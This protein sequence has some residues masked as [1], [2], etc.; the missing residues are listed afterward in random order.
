VTND[1]GERQ[2]KWRKDAQ[3]DRRENRDPDLLPDEA[4]DRVHGR[5]L[6]PATA[7]TVKG[8]E[9]RPT[10]YVGTALLVAGDRYDAVYGALERAAGELGWEVAEDPDYPPPRVR[11]DR[12][13]KPVRDPDNDDGLVPA[14]EDGWGPALRRIVISVASRTAQNAPDAWALLQQARAV[15]DGLD[16]LTGV[17][18]DHVI[19]VH[20]P[21]RKRPHW[22]PN[23]A[24]HWNPNPDSPLGSYGFQG[25]GGR[26]P[27]AY[28]GPRPARHDSVDGGRPV[29]AILDS[30]C[31]RHPW[32]DFVRC[33]VGIDGKAIG[34]VGDADDPEVNGDLVGPLDGGLDPISGHGTFIAGLVHQRC[35]DADIVSWRVVDSD[36]PVVESFALDTLRQVVELVERHADGRPGGMRI[37]VL[38]LSMGYYHETPD[39][40]LED[41]TLKRLLRR[42]GRCGVAVVC[43]AGNDATARRLYPAAYAPKAGQEVPADA[44]YV[45]VTS[46]G[47]DNPNGTVALFSNTGD[48]VRCYA[49]GAAVLSTM[50]P[51]QGGLM[52]MATTR[53]AGLDRESMDPDDYQAFD[54]GSGEMSGGFAL[55]SGTSFAAPVIAGEIAAE[56]LGSIPATGDTREA[57]VERTRAAVETVVSKATSWKRAHGGGTA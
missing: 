31:G 47:A 22:N 50:P 35:P 26:Q 34:Y 43:S 57:A 55:W 39:D 2:D 20:K 21:R 42:L 5:V 44:D 45:P 16:Q 56:L 40:I 54:N 41:P 12:E 3:D 15:A 24:P 37:D 9:P 38:N 14:A 11:V 6:D 30:G 18:L 4:L 28:A 19:E 13:G 53:A 8:V 1:Y 36:G 32:L 52:P 48:W 51:F 7:L 17:G 27:V 49:P 29:V 46:V 33:N 25:S 23:P 10:T